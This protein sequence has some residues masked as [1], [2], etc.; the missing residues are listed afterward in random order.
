MEARNRHAAVLPGDLHRQLDVLPACGLEPKVLRG[1]LRTFGDYVSCCSAAGVKPLPPSYRSVMAHLLSLF[2]QRRAVSGFASVCSRLKWVM[3]HIFSQ[4]WLAEIDPHSHAMLLAARRALRKLD[5]RPVRK[6]RP[7]HFC[8]LVALAP[9]VRTAHDRLCYGFWCVCRALIFR[10]GELLG[11]RATVGNVKHF[12]SEHGPFFV[13]AFF[14]GI[15]QPKAH[16]TR[17]APYLL[18]SLRR[19]P[20]AY[21]ALKAIT[22]QRP[23]E[24][25][26][27]G[28]LSTH[29]AVRWLRAALA[30]AGVPSP[31]SYGGHSARRGGFSDAVAR[32]VP[33]K[34]AEVQG[35]WAPGSLTAIAEYDDQAIWRRLRYF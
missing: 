9:H 21:T 4:P 17:Q 13:F 2:L 15:Y 6:A 20:L 32:G 30:R 12:C 1:Y 22:R 5:V 11:R 23:P 25:P 28:S 16:K 10:A 3:R 14:P 24:A 29:T 27:F 35:H 26:L 19:S 8:T 34:F 18:V 7:L 33:A 31:G